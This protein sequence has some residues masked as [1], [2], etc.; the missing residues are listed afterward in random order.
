ML[1]ATRHDDG[2][3][4]YDRRPACDPPNERPTLLPRRP[5]PRTS[6]STGPASPRSRRG[7]VRRPDHLD[8]RRRDLQR[9]LRDAARP[10][11]DRRREYQEPVDAFVAEQEATHA[12]A[13]RRSAS[14][15]TS[16]GRTTSCCR[17]TTGSRSLLPQGLGDRGGEADEVAPAPERLPGR[18]RARDRAARALARRSTRIRSPRARR[19][20]RRAQGAAEA[21][22]PSNDEFRRETSATPSETVEIT[23]DEARGRLRAK[24][25]PWRASRG[26]DDR[27]QRHQ[28]LAPDHR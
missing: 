16:A 11:P 20:S 15:T 17:C 3:G 19:G 7:P 13:R 5:V 6:P 28:P 8:A 2:W 21:L 12:R 9:P 18:G 4:V 23:I 27:G 22:A 24:G 26:T 1:A 25:A 14:P 10:P